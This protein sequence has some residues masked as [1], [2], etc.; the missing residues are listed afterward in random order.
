MSKIKVGD[1]VYLTH[2][3]YA[4]GILAAKVS[5][6]HGTF[7][8]IIACEHDPEGF[9]ETYEYCTT[10]SDAKLKVAQRLA[11]DRFDTERRLATLNDPE[12]V[13]HALTI[14]EAK[15]DCT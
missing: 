9:L 11:E 5:C 8:D 6:I 3:A 13:A 7:P 2:N 4:Q 14:T 15:K 10:E 1:T 12:Y